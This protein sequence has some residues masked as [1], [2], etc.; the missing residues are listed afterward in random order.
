MKRRIA[1]FLAALLAVPAALADNAT[2]VF[3]RVSPSVVGIRSL[4]EAGR[5]DGQ[6]SGV[7]VGP[8]RIV[9]NCHVVRDARTL[10]I[11]RGDKTLA[12]RWLSADLPRDL[13]LLEVP[14]LDAPAIKP[15]ASTTLAPGERIYAVGNPLGFG[16]AVSD[17]LVSTLAPAGDGSRIY[18]TAAL[19]PGSSG[20]GLFDGEGRLLGITTAVMSL[21]QNL[22]VAL[23]AEWIDDFAA[24]GTPPPALPEAPPPE[25]RWLIEAESLR[26]KRDWKALAGLAIRWTEAQPKSP[27]A[28]LLLGLAQQN[29]GQL[30][31]AEKSQRVSLALHKQ[32][33]SAWVELGSTLNMLERKSEAEQAF[34]QAMTHNPSSGYPYLQLARNRYVNKRYDDAKELAEKAAQR[35]A[36]DVFV[37]WLLGDIEEK[38]G[39]PVAAARAFRIA[40]RH[41][42]DEPELTASLARVLAAAGKNAESRE[43]IAKA[44]SAAGKMSAAEWINL[45]H[46]ESLN[47]RYTDAEIAFRKALEADP[48]SADAWVNLAY[49]QYTSGRREAAETSIDRALAI[50]PDHVPA[51]SQRAEQRAMIKDYPAAR[52]LLERVVVLAPQG[53]TGWRWLGLVR[54]ETLDYAGAADAYR[55]ATALPGALAEDWL[56]LGNACVKIRQ[57]AEAESAF[58]TAE[59]IAPGN[60]DVLLGLASL[61]GQ[62]G[63]NEGALRYLERILAAD[64]GSAHAWSSK[65]YALIRLGKLDAAVQ[66]LET[67]VRLQPDFANAWINFGQALLM[68]KQLGRAIQALERATALA[69]AAA[70]ARF[71]LSQ[72]YLASR[73]LPQARVNL[74]KLSSQLPN[75]PQTL[76]L[77]TLLNL[78]EGKVAE[79][80][81]AFLLLRAMNPDG[82]QAL[83]RD[84][85]SR[86]FPSAGSLP[87]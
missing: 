85:I 80:K 6:G 82:A 68:Q 9:T 78:A 74:E 46:A 17:G 44:P 55:K 2:R 38:R 56:G 57:F 63:D 64:P 35:S 72:A 48:R 59:N 60:N 87:E 71:Y 34:Q 27:T 70:D 49:V 66:A 5:T 7:V 47:K 40:L 16:L 25:T 13:C 86:G 61:T 21:G 22:N 20:G 67:A 50:D 45:G 23:P 69:P 54:S 84:A 51:L 65:G 3:E 41:R 24:R 53:V 79:A 75:A 8:A 83:R 52:P 81:A 43:V 11:Q 42:P 29:L 77:S 58:K 10:Q 73:L 33:V 15:R 1:F 37:W 32:N 30:A 36:P 14:G 12:A 19:S 62:R 31:S 28:W 26:I 18:I 76:T 4:D 39:D